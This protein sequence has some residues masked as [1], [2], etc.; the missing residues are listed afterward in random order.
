MHCTW[1]EIDA[2]DR[3]TTVVLLPVGAIEAHGPHLPLGTDAIISEAVART[4]LPLLQ[5]HGLQGIILPTLNFSVAKFAE[6]FPGTISF[7]ASSFVGVVRDLTASLERQGFRRLA[8]T[9]SHLDPA[10]LDC[11]RQGLEQTSM[12]VA[13][14]NIVRRKYAQRLTA[15]FQSGA[16]HAGQYEGS[17]V[18]AAQP[19]L[20]R[21]ETA[22]QLVDNPASL[23]TAIQGGLSSF[24]EAGGPQA[25]FGSP[26]NISEQEGHATLEILAQ[27]LVDEILGQAS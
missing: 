1:T 22:K 11:L 7:S 9:N 21:W 4:T 17:I 6:S 12:Q 10:H 15:E 20:V 19:E 14:P 18:A 5:T 23:V 13:Y 2:L 8:V 27:I 26:R 16:C 25:Y 24:Q 3:D